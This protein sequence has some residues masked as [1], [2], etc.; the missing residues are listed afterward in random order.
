MLCNYA[1]NSTQYIL[2]L[3]SKGTI[4]RVLQFIELDRSFGR[5]KAY[6]K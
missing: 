6:T 4:R 3:R 2:T 1:I 5:K